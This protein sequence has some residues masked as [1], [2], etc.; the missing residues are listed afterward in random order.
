MWHVPV[1]EEWPRSSG[2]GRHGP[3][4]AKERQ[5]APFRGRG[6]SDS[7]GLS[8]RAPVGGYCRLVRTGLA[9]GSRCES[10]D[11]LVVVRAVRLK[12]V[13]QQWGV[14]CRRDL[15]DRLC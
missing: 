10:C 8:S 1:G 2:V 4:G 5:G 9:W 6:L 15:L 7:R 11:V 3:C 13:V 12:E 14:F